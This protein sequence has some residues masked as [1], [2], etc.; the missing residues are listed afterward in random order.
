[1]MS[2]YMLIREAHCTFDEVDVEGAN[3]KRRTQLHR[4]RSME[5]RRGVEY[6]SGGP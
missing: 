1:M 6:D 4:R 3:R 2:S 5:L